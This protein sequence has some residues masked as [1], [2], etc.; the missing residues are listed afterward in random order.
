MDGSI[1]TTNG[2][3]K[4]K[5]SQWVKDNI[6][7]NTLAHLG[8]YA[9]YG[10]GCIAIVFAAISL[11]TNMNLPDI[12]NWIA[13]YFGATFTFAYCLL[14]GVAAWSL[15]RLAKVLSD[16]VQGL[17]FWHQ[18]GM[19]AANGISTLALTFT[20]L[21]ISLGIGS[22]S[23]QSLTPENVNNVISILTTQFSMAFMTTV[24][25]LPTATALRAWLS[26]LFVKRQGALCQSE[27]NPDH[28]PK[29]NT[30]RGVNALEEL[31]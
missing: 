8:K 31:S 1:A 28:K 22:L 7:A 21:G 23:E 14:V 11:V 16:D 24:I 25:G 6:K 10:L 19:Q 15:F 4:A 18:V 30:L 17:H 20:L 27:Q 5:A 3:A 9:A 29:L 26:I 13:K 2:L 12:V